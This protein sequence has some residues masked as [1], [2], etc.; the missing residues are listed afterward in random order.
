MTREHGRK[1]LP[2]TQSVDE[3]WS[4]VDGWRSEMGGALRR[5][6]DLFF[7][8]EA[9]RA[10]FTSV[11]NNSEIEN[12]ISSFWLRKTKKPVLAVLLVQKPGQPFKLFRGTP[13][14]CHTVHHI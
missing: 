6:V 8:D 1:G 3:L 10:E 4:R 13:C 7:A 12:D 9:F 2:I 5:A 14:S 11:V